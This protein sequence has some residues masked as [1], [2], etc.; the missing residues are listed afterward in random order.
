MKDQRKCMVHFEDKGVSKSALEVL[1]DS[2]RFLARIPKGLGLGLKNQSLLE[3]V[4]LLA[5]TFEII[6]VGRLM[7]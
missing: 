7:E 6:A 3:N 1:D 2:G 4:L 5:T